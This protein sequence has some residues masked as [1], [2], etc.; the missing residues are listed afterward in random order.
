MSTPI[1]DCAISAAAARGD[2]KIFQFLVRAM[3]Y[4][5][6]HGAWTRFPCECQPP[7]PVPTPEQLTALS[8]R[9]SNALDARRAARAQAHPNPVRF[10]K[11]I[12]PII[13]SQD[14]APKYET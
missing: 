2:E 14:E 3:E 5:R 1:S 13:K 12:F 6:A 7:C 10:D 9:I 4:N 8:Q 11:W